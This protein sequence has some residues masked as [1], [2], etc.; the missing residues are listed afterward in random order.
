MGWSGGGVGGRKTALREWVGQTHSSHVV[1]LLGLQK[2]TQ[3]EF[4]SRQP[5][6]HFDPVSVL[7]GL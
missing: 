2:V 4:S 6:K 5:T 7:K 3:T 1:F